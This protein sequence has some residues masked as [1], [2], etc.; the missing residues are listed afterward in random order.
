MEVLFIEILGGLFSLV[1]FL[2]LLF[3]LYPAMK[4]EWKENGR[5]WRYYYIVCGDGNRQSYKQLFSQLLTAVM[6]K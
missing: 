2:L 3:Y 1:I 4:K 5:D 6:K